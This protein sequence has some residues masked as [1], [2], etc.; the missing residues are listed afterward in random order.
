MRTETKLASPTERP[1]R[2]ST[3]LGTRLQILDQRILNLVYGALL[4]GKRSNRQVLHCRCHTLNL[5]AM[6]DLPCFNDPLRHRPSIPSPRLALRIRTSRRRITK[7]SVPTVIT[8][9]CFDRYSH[10]P[11]C[12][13]NFGNGLAW[14][15]RSPLR[16]RLIP[17]A[18][19][20][21]FKS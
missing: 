10:G 20:L 15:I 5:A 18:T 9:I 17:R 21:A 6:L 11:D 4:R 12:T 3:A 14:T 8:A 1:A 19:R 7:P 13:T 2:T 16:F